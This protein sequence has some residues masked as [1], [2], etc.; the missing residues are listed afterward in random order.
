MLSQANMLDEFQSGIAAA[1]QKCLDDAHRRLQAVLQ[2]LPV[3]TALFMQS[4]HHK[5]DL[6]QRSMD[7]ASPEHI[8]ALGYSITRVNGKAV[9]SLEDVAVGDKVVTTVAGGEITGVITEK[10]I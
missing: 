1:A 2:R 6:C 8:L 5:L 9:R 7:A 10:K 4:Q 3:A